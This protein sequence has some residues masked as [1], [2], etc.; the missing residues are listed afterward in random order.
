[1]YM[2]LMMLGRQTAEPI[3]PEPSAFEVELVLE[4]LKNNNQQVLIKFQQN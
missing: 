4:K 3:V 2:D 1:M